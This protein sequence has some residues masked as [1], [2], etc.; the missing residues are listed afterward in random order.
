MLESKV[1]GDRTV[2]YDQASDIIIVQNYALELDKD[3]STP[4]NREKSEYSMLMS[5]NNQGKRD[6][7]AWNNLPVSVNRAGGHS[8]TISQQQ[9]SIFIND[10]SSSCI[11]K[12]ALTHAAGPET[13]LASPLA[14]Q[15][16]ATIQL[17]ANCFDS[18][19]NHF[20][21]SCSVAIYS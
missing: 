4:S 16:D 6:T 13:I 8:P 11:G 2:S 14:Q 12:R 5:L 7:S 1:G 9:P 3:D 17:Q 20:F 10:P 15:D 19:P 21:N 18:I